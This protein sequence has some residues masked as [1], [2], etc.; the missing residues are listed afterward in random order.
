MNDISFRGQLLLSLQRALLGTITD[1]VQSVTCSWDSSTIW[2][3]FI[4]VD[5]PSE[6]ELDDAECVSS[7]VISDFPK[8]KIVT[9]FEQLD[10]TVS[11]KGSA[12]TAWAFEKKQ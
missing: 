8:Y 5:K 12:L 10:K 7:E 6:E 1:N 9:L 11:L 3:K 2:V 4:Y